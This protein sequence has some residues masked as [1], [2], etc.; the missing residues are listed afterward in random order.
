MNCAFGDD[1]HAV[2]NDT[3]VFAMDKNERINRFML[4]APLVYY[5][6]VALRAFVRLTVAVSY[7]HKRNLK[8]TT[9]PGGTFSRFP[10][11]KS[12]FLFVSNISK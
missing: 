12:V 5:N 4:F 11:E 8:G 2:R 6:K 3:I 10:I 9:R 1:I 7:A